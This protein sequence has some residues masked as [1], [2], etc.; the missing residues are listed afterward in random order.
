MP[1]GPYEE[2]ETHTLNQPED[3]KSADL[4]APPV[5]G[6]SFGQWISRRFLRV[7]GGETGAA[8]RVRL[9]LIC[10][11]IFLLALGVRALHF[12]DS[13]SVLHEKGQ[14]MASNARHYRTEALRML[15]ER[16]ILFPPQR[17]D[18]G[19]ARLILH[20][21]GYSAFIAANFGVFGNSDFALTVIQIILDS[22]SALVVVLIAA[23]FFSYAVAAISGALAG[24]SPQFAHYSLWTSPD[25]LCVLPILIA[26]YLII[27]AV[28]R[29][30]LL[31]I[32]GAGAMVG[33]S[34]WL[35]ANAMLLIPVLAV[36]VFFLVAKGKRI[37]YSA[38]LVGATVAV[39]M[40]ITIR[41]WILYH[42]FIP[43]SIAGGENLIV[44]IADFDKEG[45]FGMPASDHEV[46]PREAVWYNRPDYAGTP[47]LP[48]GV[49][50]DQARYS[51]GL[52]VIRAN[53][54]WFF[55]V[56]VKRAFFMLR[57]ND[58]SRPDWPFNTSRVPIVSAAP[59]VMHTSTA[60]IDSEP[61]WSSSGASLLEDTQVIVS[62]RAQAA[63]EAGRVRISSDNSAFGDQFASAPIAVTPKTDYLLKVRATAIQGLAAAKVT[64]SDRRIALASNALP[65]KESNADTNDQSKNR[66]TDDATQQIDDNDSALI[67]MVFGT[68]TLGEIRAVI[69][70]NGEGSQPPLIE[71]EG[72]ELFHLGATPYQWTRYPRP[73]IRGV[74][75]NLFKT[76][77]MLPIVVAGI[78]LLAITREWR[79][80]VLLLAV[81]LYYLVA[82]SPLSTEFRYILAIH[83]FL[84]VFA[85][86]ALTSFGASMALAVS[87]VARRVLETKRTRSV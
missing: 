49:Q 50:R 86:V 58:Y 87:V 20:P 57:S 22:I 45:R 33:V 61:V 72:V 43:V 53:P 56:V 1:P 34:C 13:Y 54:G 51:R 78:L 76:N 24:L 6:R 31:L 75:K 52:E 84:Y 63:S 46:G 66:I 36:A 29:P 42:H 12:Q 11:A 41:N 85:A 4:T 71:V 81:P 5:S 37:L 25:T 23:E 79:A 28:K 35:R 44:G 7:R 18:P 83:S 80:F 73:V 30:N 74:Q 17:V 67:Q 15:K 27:K 62:R 48:D 70:N 32:I 65:G 64:S 21:P 16:W 82:Q 3:A 59:A 60:A 26:V 2:V 9:A 77:I 68:D 38:V 8:P 55:G 40:P 39:V 10:V 19:D 47:W 69:S 14:W